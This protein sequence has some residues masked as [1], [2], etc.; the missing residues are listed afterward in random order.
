[1]NIVKTAYFHSM[2]V[3]VDYID[4]WAHSAWDLGA[5]VNNIVCILSRFGARGIG[6]IDERNRIPEELPG[7]TFREF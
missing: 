3:I 6:S 2:Q 1:M 7:P 5:K 4:F